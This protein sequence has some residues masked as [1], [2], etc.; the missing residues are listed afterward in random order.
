VLDRVFHMEFTSR[1]G[2]VRFHWKWLSVWIRSFHTVSRPFVMIASQLVRIRN[3]S[4][5]ERASSYLV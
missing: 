4:N 1:E 3:H 5:Q 2:P